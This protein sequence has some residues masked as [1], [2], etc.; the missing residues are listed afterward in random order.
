V[1]FVI[2]CEGEFLEGAAADVVGGVGAF[3]GAF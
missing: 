2:D 1:S 3:C